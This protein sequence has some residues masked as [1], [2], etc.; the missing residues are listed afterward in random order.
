MKKLNPFKLSVF[1]L[2]AIFGLVLNSCSTESN[3]SE[4][5]E[6]SEFEVKKVLAID[7]YSGIADNAIAEAFIGKASTDK[8]IQTQRDT[9]CYST[10][11]SELGYTMTF[12]N[13]TL[14][15]ANK[16]NGTLNVTYAVNETSSTFTASYSDFY[17]GTIRLDGTRTFT[18]SATNNENEIAFTVVSDMVITLEDGEIITEAGTKTTSLIISEQHI[19]VVVSGTWA[20]VENGDT[21]LITVTEKL[22]KLIACDY[23]SEGLFILSKNGVEVNVDL[24]DGSCDNKASIIYPNGKIEEVTL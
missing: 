12:D 21:Y 19:E 8:K 9:E 15:D 7:D 4:D 2:I 1:A 16:V 3:N 18:I 14:N 22:S 11:Y 5:I 20:L 10:T 24:G 6:I 17:V 23:F 13:C